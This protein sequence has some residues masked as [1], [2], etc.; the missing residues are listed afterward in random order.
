VTFVDLLD[1]WPDLPTTAEAWLGEL[2]GPTAVRVPGRDRSRVRVVSG[3]L[4]GNEPS[5]LRA[6]FEVLR[7]RPPL[8]TDA[9]FFIGAVEAASLHPGLAHRMVPG[10]RDMN[11]CFRAP[12]EGVD[13]KVAE[14]ALA[15]MRTDGLEA[16]VDLHNNTGHNPAYGVG[17][18]ADPGRLGVASF[19]ARRYVASSLGLGALHEAFPERTAAVTIEC[20]RAGDP[21]A[22]AL[23][24]SGLARFLVEDRIPTATLPDFQ[25]LVDPVRVC[26]RPNVKLAFGAHRE[27]DA[28]LTMAIDV[29]RHNFQQLDGG[30]RMGWV[31]RRAPW[32]IEARNQGNEDVT[33]RLFELRG[34]ELVT[35]VPIVPIMMTTNATIAA[36]DC[37]FYVVREV[38]DPYPPQASTNG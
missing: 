4:H 8:A 23:A 38:E 33:E 22:D 14:A 34:S 9:V 32:P 10:R 15:L 27:T 20:G 5:G 36:I 35:R 11:R 2:R 12:F 26:L 30:T 28:D 17:V 31:R 37:L 7:R 1:G 6:I 19:F 29:D 21:R 16:V 3:L 13:G 24:S 25:V 18:T